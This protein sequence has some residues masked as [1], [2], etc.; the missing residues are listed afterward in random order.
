MLQY[1]ILFSRFYMM[2]LPIVIV[3]AGAAGVGMG[4]LLKHLDLPFVLIDQ[5]KVGESFLR[6]PKETRF[7]S[8]SFT[9][10]AFGAVDLNAVTPDTSPAF[11]LQTEHPSGVDYAAYLN[12]LVA[13]FD[14]PFI[15][16]ISVDSI[17]HHRQ[18]QYPF[19]LE[20]NQGDINA[21]HL[22]W[23]GGEFQ[24]PDKN[25]FEGA[26][27]C[28]HYAE[29]PTWTEL[30]GDEFYIIGSYES[31]VDAAYQLAKQGKKITLF[32]GNNQLSK[33]TGDSSYSISPFTRDRFHSIAN[34]IRIIAEP[35]IRVEAVSG[36]HILTTADGT[37]YHSNTK[38]INCTG[39]R[40]S[41]SKIKHLFEFQRGQVLLNNV[42]ESTICPNL[43]LSGPQVRHGNAIFC[44]IYKYRQRF[45]IVGEVLSQRLNGNAQLRAKIIADYQKNQFYLNDLS[46]CEDDCVC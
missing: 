40:T 37:Q 41:L 9:G 46:C 20:T 32:D 15:P 29:V 19:T 39:F 7:I 5:G 36:S 33:R 11:S 31:G 42:D 4:V 38:P 35:I 1:N 21:Q 18:S 8:P 16:N 30:E 25:G 6:W 45:G 27:L 43:F 23:A 3:G 44:F 10:N 28:I 24:Y 34:N 26:S 17:T 14:L 12:V 22:I 13:H 2:K